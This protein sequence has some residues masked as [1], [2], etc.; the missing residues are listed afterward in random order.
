MIFERN[1]WA[2]LSQTMEA[3][4]LVLIDEIILNLRIA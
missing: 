2:M 4:K 3:Y 1:E